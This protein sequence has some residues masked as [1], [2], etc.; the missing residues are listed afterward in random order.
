MAGW[1]VTQAEGGAEALAQFERQ[2]ADVV[3]LDLMMPEMDG[4]ETLARLREVDP[5]VPVVMVSAS[6][7]L[8]SDPWLARLRVS[9]IIAKPVDP[10]E[11]PRLVLELLGRPAARIDKPVDPLAAARAKYIARLPAAIDALTAAV[12]ALPNAAH[13]DA[14]RDARG[15][16]HKLKGSAGTYGLVALGD[17]CGRLESALAQ[18]IDLDVPARDAL[19][20]DIETLLEAVRGAA[21]GG[22]R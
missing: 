9:G 16:A 11:L 5:D 4:C 19:I 6:A 15:R 8:A 21:P 2:G 14:W 17:A 12:R 10:F 1:E 7:T 20:G 22:D 3:L 18:G 13:E